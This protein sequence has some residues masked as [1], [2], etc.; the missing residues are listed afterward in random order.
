MECEKA[1]SFCKIHIGEPYTH[2]SLN[3]NDNQ[4]PLW[5]DFCI[6]ENAN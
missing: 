3:L 6:S 2:I 4:D 1:S 5:C